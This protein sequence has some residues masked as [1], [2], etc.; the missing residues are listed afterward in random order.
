NSEVFGTTPS[1]TGQPITIGVRNVSP[2]QYPFNG[3]IDEVEIFDHA[4]SDAQV[5]AIFNAGAGGK[6]KPCLPPPNDMVSWWPGD[7]HPNDI[8]GT[9]HGTLQNGA[10]YGTGHVA[11]A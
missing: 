1:A 2:V 10:G 9:H 8:Q 6:C 11:Q 3:L 4:L 5:L 7:G